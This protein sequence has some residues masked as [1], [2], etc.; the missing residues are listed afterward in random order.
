MK[1]PSVSDL[2][3][4]VSGGAG[5]RWAGFVALFAMAWIAPLAYLAPLGFAPMVGLTGLLA[6][7]L[8]WGTG[9]PR[10]FALW[11][12]AMLALLFG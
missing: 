2:T 4:S 10:P 6:I 5:D 8:F 1:L 7:P 3:A 12:V 11:P 9:R